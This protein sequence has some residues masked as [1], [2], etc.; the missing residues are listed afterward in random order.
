MASVTVDNFVQRRN[1]NVGDVSGTFYDDSADTYKDHYIYAV[2]YSEVSAAGPWKQATVLTTDSQYSWPTAGTAAGV[3]FNLPILLNTNYSGGLWV[4]VRIRRSLFGGHPTLTAGLEGYWKCWD[5]APTPTVVGAGDFADGTL[6][7]GN[8][9]DITTTGKIVR[10]LDISTPSIDLSAVEPVAGTIFN[11][12][13]PFSMSAWVYPDAMPNPKALIATYQGGAGVGAGFYVMHLAGPAVLA[14]ELTDGVNAFLCTSGLV[15]LTA[16]AW[17][18]FVITY[19]GS[20]TC[21]GLH[22]YIGGSEETAGN[23]GAVPLTTINNN[24]LT[25]GDYSDGGGKFDGRFCEIGLWS[26]L[27]TDAEVVDLYNTDSGLEY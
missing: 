26:K 15:P 9:E 1:T 16:T 5:D 4:K 6:S 22:I 18:F 20:N 7:A 24:Q 14:F 25:I 23:A 10:S 3:P 21:N 27:L 17:N 12:N 11:I 19:D 13:S 2:Y 8:S